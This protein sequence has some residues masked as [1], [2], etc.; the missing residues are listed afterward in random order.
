MGGPGLHVR[1]VGG[2]AYI[3][4]IEQ[5]DAAIVT[6]AQFGAQAVEPVLTHAVEIGGFE[7][8]GRPFVEGKLGRPDLDP[9]VVIRRAVG[10]KPGDRFA[11]GINLRIGNRERIVHGITPHPNALYWDAMIGLNG[12]KRRL[13]KS[14]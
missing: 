13:N 4:R 3:E 10:L 14:Q 5:D 6:L 12:R 9:V 2:V 8:E 1:G 11:R 7:P